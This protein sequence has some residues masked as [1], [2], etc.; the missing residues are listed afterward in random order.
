VV[1]DPFLYFQ[2][3]IHWDDCVPV[4]QLDHPSLHYELFPQVI[5]QSSIFVVSSGFPSDV[6]LCN[7]GVLEMERGGQHRQ[8]S[9]RLDSSAR[10][11]L[12]SFRKES[13]LRK[14]ITSAKRTYYLSMLTQQNEDKATK[15]D[16]VYQLQHSTTRQNF[17]LRYI[18][19]IFFVM[20]TWTLT[21]IATLITRVDSVTLTF[22]SA[23]RN[24]SVTN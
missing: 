18:I 24:N 23:F 12:F 19:R 20:V 21:Q 7:L 3:P 13:M 4:S 2:V 9:L 14:S 17:F 22:P 16:H 6:Y 5:D 10:N 15:D 1:T 11:S 8:V